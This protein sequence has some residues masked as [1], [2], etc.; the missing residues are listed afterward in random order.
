MKEEGLI[1]SLDA[2]GAFKLKD[3]ALKPVRALLSLTPP[4]FLEQL[5]PDSLEQKLLASIVARREINPATYA[6]T[7]R[8][9]TQEMSK[10]L[11]NLI[12]ANIVIENPSNLGAYGLNAPYQTAVKE[13]LAELQKD[14]PKNGR[15]I[16]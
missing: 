13:K 11:L 14:R 7:Q 1:R 5:Q 8:I 4:P 16:G 10:A 2:S 6:R 9:P 3:N 15:G 12:D